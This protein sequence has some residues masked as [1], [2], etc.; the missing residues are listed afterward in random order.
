MM[1]TGFACLSER[2][3]VPHKE[4]KCLHCLSFN[5]P[6]FRARQRKREDYMG[7]L[8]MPGKGVAAPLWGSY[9]IPMRQ[10]SPQP[11]SSLDETG[12]G[13]P[14]R[15]GS[16]MSISSSAHRDLE[17]EL[18]LRDSPTRE[19]EP[20][21]SPSQTHGQT[22]QPTLSSPTDSLSGLAGKVGTSPQATKDLPDI[23]SLEVGSGQGEDGIGSEPGEVLSFPHTKNEAPSLPSKEGGPG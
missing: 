14:D 17:V 18:A 4:L 2:H 16:L 6:S 15:Y 10:N 8:N 11:V 13:T 5:V 1:V 9:R 22:A 20:P 3:F 7:G 23:T 19:S 12:R 21:V